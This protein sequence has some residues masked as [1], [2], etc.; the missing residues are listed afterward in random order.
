MTP[1]GGEPTPGNARGLLAAG[2][3]CAPCP[4]IGWQESGGE[5][6]RGGPRPRREIRA[7]GD[8]AIGAG[9]FRGIAANRGYKAVLPLI[10]PRVPRYLL[11]PIG[12]NAAEI[13][14]AA[15]GYG[16]LFLPTDAKKEAR[17]G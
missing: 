1:Q 6:M 15:Q 5:F 9:A 8:G 4:C 17:E 11:G 14:A 2:R 3:I 7:K 10:A 16:G 12:K 13:E